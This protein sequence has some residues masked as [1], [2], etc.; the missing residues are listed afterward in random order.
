MVQVLSEQM[1]LGRKHA[2]QGFLMASLPL[3]IIAFKRLAGTQV[4]L[5]ASTPSSSNGVFLLQQAPSGRR[6]GRREEA[7]CLQLTLRVGG[8][9]AHGHLPERSRRSPPVAWAVGTCLMPI[10]LVLAGR[11]GGLRGARTTATHTNSSY[12]GG[13]WARKAVYS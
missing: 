4:H 2:T 9:R 10:W 6:V 1:D 3:P 7:E 12:R 11:N 8:E 5:L 13:S